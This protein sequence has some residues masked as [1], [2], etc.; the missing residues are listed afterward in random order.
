MQRSN[1]LVAVAARVYLFDWYRYTAS[2]Y[3]ALPGAQRLQPHFHHFLRHS[4]YFSSSA[5]T[6]GSKKRGKKR[7]RV[8]TV[9]VHPLMTSC[10]QS[11]LLAMADEKNRP[12]VSWL[13][14]AP[15][16][17]G[18]AIVWPEVAGKFDSA[19]LLSCGCFQPFLHVTMDNASSH[20]SVLEIGD[21]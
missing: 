3:T 19:A 7:T 6:A 8:D 14:P 12:E 18:A 20:C 10:A 9:A 16:A 21:V 2:T 4:R 11:V 15:S 5:A 13:V 17:H 1:C